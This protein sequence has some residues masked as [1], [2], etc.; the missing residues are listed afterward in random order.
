MAGELHYF[1]DGACIEWELSCLTKLDLRTTFPDRQMW[2]R[3]ELRFCPD[4]LK[5]VVQFS[6]EDQTRLREK[7]AAKRSSA[8]QSRIETFQNEMQVDTAPDDGHDNIRGFISR[9]SVSIQ[10]IEAAFPL[11]DDVRQLLASGFMRPVSA[12]TIRDRHCDYF[13]LVSNDALRRAVCCCCGRRVFTKDLIVVG[14]AEIPNREILKPAQPHPAHVLHDGILLHRLGFTDEGT[15]YICVVCFKHLKKSSMPPLALAN[16]MFIGDIPFELRVL[17]LAECILV[18]K[19]FPAVYIIKMYPCNPTAHYWNNAL[20]N[21][22][23][24]GN[25]SSYPLAPEDVH[26]YVNSNELPPSPRILCAT[27][28]ISFVGPKGNPEKCFPDVVLV[29]RDRVRAALNWLCRNN[30]LYADVQISE[31]NLAMLP[32]NGVPEEIVSGAH[33]NT[34]VS[35]LAPE[36]DD[37]V[38][39]GRSA[40]DEEADEQEVQYDA[41]LSYGVS[42]MPEAGDA[43]DA[44]DNGPSIAPQVVPLQSSSVVDAMGSDLTDS[45][46]LAAALENTAASAGVHLHI[47]QGNQFVNEYPRVDSATQQRTV[48]DPSNPNHLLGCFPWL[49]PYGL[50]GFETERTVNVPYEVHARWALDYADSRFRNDYFFIPMV[51]GVIRKRDFAHAATL[52]MSSGEFTRNLNALSQL[53]P[54]DFTLAAQEE[55]QDA[56]L[57]LIRSMIWGTVVQ[58]GPPSLWVTINPSDIH[59][60]VAQVL[61]GQDIDLDN[62]DPGVGP[63]SSERAEVI[64]KD[65]VAGAFFCHYVIRGVLGELFGLE[66]AH[67]SSHVSRK[68]GVLGKVA[69]YVGTIESQGRGTLHLHI[70][71]WLE[72]CPTQQL[73]SKALEYPAF[74]ERVKDYIS[75]VIHAD[76]D[77]L[78]DAQ[79]HALPKDPNVSYNQPVDPDHPEYESLVRER[80]RTLA[81]NLQVHSCSPYKCLVKRNGQMACKRGAP[82]DRA[83]SDW[84]EQDGTWGP[85][86]HATMINGYN[87]STLV[88]AL[89][90]NDAKLVTNGPETKDA[91][92][93]I[94]DYETK[95]NR[96]T[97]NTSALIGERMRAPDLDN[98]TTTDIAKQTK[99][100][101]N[102]CLNTLSRYQEFGGPQMAAALTG[103]PDRYLS[104]HYAT[105]YL[106]AVRFVLRQE[107]PE[108]RLPLGY[109]S[110]ERAPHRKLAFVDGEVELKDQ[111]REYQFRGDL[112]E[113]FSLYD[114]MLETYEGKPLRGDVPQSGTGPSAQP[115]IPYRD[116]I[117]RSR[118]RVMRRDG[119]ETMPNFVG[120]W[121]PRNDSPEERELYCSMILAVFRPWRRLCDLKG[122]FPTFDAAFN[123]FIGRAPTRLQRLLDNV[124]YYHL[125]MDRR[126]A[127]RNETQ[128]LSPEQS[129]RQDSEDAEAARAEQPRVFT[130]ADVDALQKSQVNVKLA[131]FG[132]KAVH[133]GRDVG[134]FKGDSMT[135]HTTLPPP[136]YQAEPPQMERIEGWTTELQSFSRPLVS[137]SLRGVGEELQPHV[138]TSSGVQLAPVIEHQSHQ[139]RVAIEPIPRHIPSARAS[140]SELKSDQRMVHNIV[141]G[142]LLKHLNGEPHSQ[143]LMLCLGE[144][145]TGKSRLIH[146]IARTYIEH[147]VESWLART[148]TS[149]VAATL[150][151]GETLHSWLGVGITQHEGNEWM[152]KGTREIQQRRR[153]NILGKRLLIIDECS[154]MTTKLLAMTSQLVEWVRSRQPTEGVV[155]VPSRPFGGMDVLMLG[156]FHQ[157][158][159]VRRG[160]TALYD[161]CKKPSEIMGQE[162]YKQFEDVVS[163][164]EQMRVQDAGWLDLLRH[165]R[166]G[167]CTS[168][169]VELLE[170]LTLTSTHCQRP[171]FDSRPWDDVVL[172]T[173]RRAVRDEWNKAAILEHSHRSGQAMYIS[174][175]EDLIGGSRVPSVEE[176]YAIASKKDLDLE[177]EI[178]LARGMRVMI[179]FNLATEAYITN[180]TQGSIEDIWLDPREP[181]EHDRDDEGRIKLIYPP[182]LILFRPDRPSP[183][184]LNGVPASLV[185][186]APS[187]QKFNIKTMGGSVR[188]SCRQLELTAAYAFTDYKS[189][190]QTLDRVLIDLDKPP[191]GGSAVTAFN[192][193]VALSRV[194]NR[195]HI[196]I[197]RPFDEKIFTTLPSSELANEDKRLMELD[198]ATRAK[199]SVSG[200]VS[201]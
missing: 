61:A 135:R 187:V 149:G 37:Y 65:P 3:N 150:I 94:S 195:D 62:F 58:R 80:E 192:A 7:A 77:N 174:P 15:V 70:L 128:I 153:R 169:H 168:A 16:G 28:C 120:K 175:R 32:E 141:E 83:D 30:P 100:L 199:Y 26:D 10:S 54:Q 139:P 170:S 197:L 107:F 31:E 171:D 184:R 29:R 91:T 35:L 146:E 23:L 101:L 56:S 156:D 87:P 22:G 33:I 17:T 143:M 98:P 8:I 104:H 190:G 176:R 85:K 97:Y 129:A 157:F 119:H 66:A 55:S 63:S 41:G 148:A 106:D 90:N 20:F 59:N 108:L 145:G 75:S 105:I 186:I 155:N 69:A 142:Q 200:P 161:L 51:F 193:Y 21:N 4:M 122:Q 166:V 125:G 115:R 46:V 131:Q 185:P 93:Y 178:H 24:R 47:H 38:P 172:I 25:V 165:V 173:T 109:D 2:S 57:R 194:R 40:G 133:L 144:G 78:T 9:P 140:L 5:A 43:T 48:G 117:N 179:D 189:Q 124:Q 13:A 158:P 112:L 82:F 52:Q 126:Q 151:D 1:P 159:P 60:P 160:G 198:A 180:G 42:G 96:G 92:F 76:I 177:P 68:E 73:M 53:T 138:G 89:C 188:V 49:F 27:I 191:G 86:R 136:L 162:I 164:K 72:E 44:P 71:L 110:E 134:V 147:G 14:V 127:R 34:D 102:K 99:T 113:G 11:A 50:G 19:Y 183:V 103:L 154:M 18:A 181:A 167:G 130:E 79:V 45:N 111:L 132:Q 88:N 12:E 6:L 163:L 201:Q 74:R 39:N 114:F 95:G 123:D 81:R 84:V 64:A 116:G 121:F 36:I 196:R 182:A 152:A 118:V 137:S 67:G